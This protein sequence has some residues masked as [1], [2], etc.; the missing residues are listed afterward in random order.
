LNTF[1]KM[2]L[3]EEN[4]AERRDRILRAARKLVAER[5]YDG[6][7]MRDLARAARVSV[8]T[9]YNLFGGKDQILGA[10]LEAA[11]GRVASQLPTGGTSF[12]ARGMAAFEAGMRV[13]EESPEFYR[14]LMKLFLTSPETTEVRHR[15]EY[16]YIAIMAANL[17]AARAAGQLAEWAEPEIAARHM[18]GAYVCAMMGWGA[19]ELDDE[20]FRLAALSGVCHVMG[21]VARGAFLADVEAKLRE[22]HRDPNL[23][24]IRAKEVPHAVARKR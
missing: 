10:E 15:T 20:Q 3:F 14:A 7:T 6:L 2:S 5:G 1:K 13:V 23:K 16:G 18:F 11:A 9:L 22:L 8:P 19:G 24:T 12:F 17:T 21:S 4:K